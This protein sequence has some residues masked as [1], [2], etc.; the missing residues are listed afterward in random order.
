[1]KEGE[2]WDIIHL[3]GHGQQG[4]LLLEDD[5]GGSDTIDAD[6]LGALLDMAKAR[7]KLLM[8]DACYSG[9]GSQAAAREQVGLDRSAV[10]QEGAEGAALAEIAGTALPGLAQTLSQ[11]LDCAALAMR[12]PVGDAFATDLML[13]L[14]ANL[15]EN[16]QPLPAALHLALDDALASDIPRPPLSPATPI[17]VGVRAA[18]L[19]L[20]PPPQEAQRFV[21][22]TVG[23]SI[24]FPPEPERFVGR[25]QPMLRASQALARRSLKLGVLFYGMPGAGKTACALE[26]TYRH[27]HGRFQ[28]YVWHRAPEAGS[29]ISSALFNL[30]QD[31][32]TQLNAPDLGLATALDQP[33]RFR[34]Y[35]LPRLLRC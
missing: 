10:R 28:G 22:P 7:L 18:E 31:I 13:A 35:T 12:Y 17:L 21:L 27:E 29:D 4:E 30:M 19:Q 20:A 5:R 34:Q 32:Q 2:G 16:N 33:D 6:E 11:R 14:Y 9:A 23:L 24:A 25:L 1:M 26:L 8:L 15:L 3:S